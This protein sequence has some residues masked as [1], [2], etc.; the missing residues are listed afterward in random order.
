MLFRSILLSTV[1]YR[2]SYS[3]GTVK[4]KPLVLPMPLELPAR[5]D[6]AQQC[7]LRIEDVEVTETIALYCTIA[8]AFFSFYIHDYNIRK[9][10]EDAVDV[11]LWIE[12]PSGKKDNAY[13]PPND[14]T[15]GIIDW[16]VTT[17]LDPITKS[18]VY[19]SKDAD[20]RL[21]MYTRDAI[22]NYRVDCATILYFVN[23]H[24]G[25]VIAK[26]PYA[27][28]IFYVFLVIHVF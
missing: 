6:R 28:M 10:T 11:S 9:M 24:S 20:C 19:V 7:W 8:Q 25:S 27:L 12:K 18:R 17:V 4:P 13:G 5:N 23:E 15:S 16:R 14:N 2:L 3:E 1:F 21:L 22:S 26:I